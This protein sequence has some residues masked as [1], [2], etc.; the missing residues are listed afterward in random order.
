MIFD[1]WV[2]PVAMMKSVGIFLVSTVAFSS[3]TAGPREWY[4]LP[5]HV[6]DEQSEA[7]KRNRFNIGYKIKCRF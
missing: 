5:V 4:S 3:S 2:F 7:C 1:S 6:L